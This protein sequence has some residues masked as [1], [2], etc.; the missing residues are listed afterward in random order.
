MRRA[1]SKEALSLG[2]VY[3]HCTVKNIKQR[4]VGYEEQGLKEKDYTVVEDH[5]C[6]VFSL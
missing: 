4:T 1:F 3:T 5:P 2:C 6:S